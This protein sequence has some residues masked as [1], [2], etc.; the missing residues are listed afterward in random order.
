MIAND[1]YVYG[2]GSMISSTTG[3]HNCDGAIC[4]PVLECNEDDIEIIDIESEIGG[5]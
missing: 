3:F 5:A 4:T 2:G 1:V